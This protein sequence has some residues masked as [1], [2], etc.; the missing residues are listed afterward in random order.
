MNYIPRLIWRV[1]SISNVFLLSLI[2]FLSSFSTDVCGQSYV[3]TKL[4][5]SMVGDTNI[6]TDYDGNV[7]NTVDIGSQRW[8]KESLRSLHY[9]D[10]TTIQSVLAYNNDEGLVPTYGRIYTW[11]AAMKNST[12]TRTQGACPNGWHLPTDGEWTE[13]TNYLGGESVAGGHM[14]EAGTTHWMSPN[15]GADNSSDFTA[16]PTGM[17]FDG[18][19]QHFRY[20]V[21]FWTSSD[22]YGPYAWYRILYHNLASVARTN[23]FEKSTYRSVRCLCDAVTGVRHSEGRSSSGTKTNSFLLEQ[24]WPN[25][26]NPTTTIRFSLKEAASVSL[27]VFDLFGR[28]IRQLLSAKKGPGTYSII[29]DGTDHEGAEVSSGVYFY[30]LKCGNFIQVQKAMLVR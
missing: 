20:N 8:I 23:W 11:Y 22:S 4:Q 19:F 18:S 26:F 28:R 5:S 24:N 13:L 30:R 16:L 25:P 17:Y 27:D 1:R 10:G 2:L 7:Y 15:T 12:T 21:E 6:V 9:S 14:K 29:W 3:D